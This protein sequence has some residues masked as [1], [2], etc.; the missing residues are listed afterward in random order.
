[1]KIAILLI[2]ALILVYFIRP[3]DKQSYHKTILAIFGIAYFCIW[4]F[5][6]YYF[7]I[8]TPVD[9]DKNTAFISLMVITLNSKLL[10]LSLFYIMITQMQ[11]ATSS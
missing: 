11:H 7:D 8:F 10:T 5:L 9:M 2:S 3:K 6:D 1:M 4:R